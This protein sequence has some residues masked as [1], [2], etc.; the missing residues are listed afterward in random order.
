[1]RYILNRVWFF[2]SILLHLV[3]TKFDVAVRN[4]KTKQMIYLRASSKNHYTDII[5]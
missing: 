3:Y 2:L 4:K 5:R 1:M